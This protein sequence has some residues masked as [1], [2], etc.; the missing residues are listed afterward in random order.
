MFLNL[1]FNG[2]EIEKR[3]LGKKLVQLAVKV[4]WSWAFSVK[5]FLKVLPQ[6]YSIWL[7]R[8]LMRIFRK[9][10]SEFKPDEIFSISPLQNFHGIFSAAPPLAFVSNGKFIS[11]LVEVWNVVGEFLTLGSTNEHTILN[12]FAK[13]PV[14]EPISVFH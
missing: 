4:N 14:L 8:F 13:L 12:N 2:H 5:S 3:L 6:N 10:L 7:K 11:Q 1:I 9:I